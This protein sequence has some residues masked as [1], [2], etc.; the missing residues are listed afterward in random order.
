MAD[1][2]MRIGNT[3]V[4][5]ALQD[6]SASYSGADRQIQEAAAALGRA[7]FH[8]R[9]RRR[10][11]IVL[12]GHL[13]G[14]AR[15]E[16]FRQIASPPSRQSADL[17]QNAGE[18]IQ[19]PGTGDTDTVK[20]AAVGSHRIQHLADALHGVVKAILRSCGTFKTVRNGAVRTDSAHRD[21]LG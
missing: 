18:G 19:W 12:N 8:L 15:L 3:P 2:R 17:A 20:R 11:R 6:D 5:A 10:V 14:E 9:Q 1:F 7:P 4:Q 13:N 16:R 21:R